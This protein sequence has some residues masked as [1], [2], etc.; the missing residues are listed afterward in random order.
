MN[1]AQRL[2]DL[3]R[4]ERQAEA[5]EHERQVEAYLEILNRNAGEFERLIV[6]AKEGFQA[7]LTL[8]DCKNFICA[9]GPD[10]LAAW[11][12]TMAEAIGRFCRTQGFETACTCNVVTISW[13]KPRDAEGN[14]LDEP[15]IDF[16][17]P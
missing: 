7:K 9:R 5:E 17:W 10:G 4:R 2:N 3:V 6:S 11:N 13:E 16:E 12:Q 14:C 1:M 15:D 8:D